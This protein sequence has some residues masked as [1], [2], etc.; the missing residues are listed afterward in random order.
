MKKL[1]IAEKP[2]V[3]EQLAG[4]IDHCK[5][6]RE[7]Y[8]GEHYIVSWA[9]GHL[10]GLAE[11]ED[12]DKKYKQWL[13][14]YLPIIPEAF[15]FSVLE[16]AEDRFNVLGKLIASKEVDEVINACDAGREG[17]L[18][19]RN[20]YVQAG[21]KKPASRLWLS[22]YTDESIRDGFKHIRPESAY[23]DLGKAA[24]ARSEADWLVGINATRGLTRRN[25]SLVTVGRV[26]TP[27]LALIAKREKEVQAFTP[28]PYFEVDAQFKVVPHGEPTYAGLWHRGSE[29][30][31]ADQEA[32]E[33]I[34]TKCSGHR[35][36]VAS[37]AQKENRMQVPYLYDL[38]LLQRE[39]NGLNGLSA[40]RT[41]RAAQSLYEAKR[42]ITYPRTDSKYLP[43]ALRKEVVTVLDDLG[44][45][46]YAPYVQR[47]QR[48]GWKMRS[49]VFN[50]EKV[51]DHYAIIPTGTR[52]DRSSLSHDESVVY[53]LVVRRFLEQFYPEAVLMVTRVET[54]VEG[55]TFGSDGRVVKTSG[56]LEVAPREADSKDLPELKEK[57]SVQAFRV[58]SERKL[59]KAPPRFTDASIIAA[60]ETAGKL[61]D[62]EELAEAMKER[63]LGTPATRAEII[64]KLIRTGVVERKARSLVA[65]RRGIDLIDLLEAIHLSD[66]V[67]PDLTG[68]WEMSLR[69]I[70]K[71]SLGNVEFLE[72]IEGFT[73]QMIEKIKGYEAPTQIGIESAEPLGVCPI[74]G[75][76]VLERPASYVCEHHG[77]KK[78]DCKFSIPKMILR[79]SISREEALQLM[80]DKRTDMLDGFVSRRG[81][82][83]SARLLLKPDNKLEWEF[84][85]GSG[86]SSA[87]TEPVVNEEPLGRCPVCQ[88][89]VVETTEHYRCAAADCRFQMKRV[90]AGKT[91][92]RDM[93]RN[94]LEKGKT[95]LI[96]DFVSKYN[97]PFSAYLK[98]GDKGKVEFEFLNKG[99]RTGRRTTGHAGKAG[100]PTTKATRAVSSKT[101]TANKG[102]STKKTVKAKAPAR[103][104]ASKTSNNKGGAS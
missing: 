69:K 4:V 28:M 92:D 64:E 20:I 80:T 47:V 63:G 91:I 102:T 16:G 94:L 103:K 50:D 35:G 7:Y 71:G 45:G 97:R 12:Y 22:S 10:V 99:P 32:A 60:M 17:E 13:L 75:G 62:D 30:R 46:E 66:L 58:E 11:P 77:R 36:V 1:V 53:D 57:L 9:V 34:A 93:A 87:A 8:E 44:M 40:S 84:A 33:A 73:R 25:G 89:L 39:A 101:T 82:K 83:F 72:R 21:G 52:L 27:V 100:A 74:C 85:E 54:V 6:S 23:D 70:E 55:E 81:F 29:S 41:L 24:L 2:S 51:S 31:L 61:V 79:R 86:G 78:T 48:E 98:L 49:F 14:S 90:Y 37:V 68:D 67:A 95:D 38:G 76:N 104:A 5:K 88:G 56:W 42:A 18:I 43:K 65:T 19:F 26:Q 3:A 15:R 59:T 96:E